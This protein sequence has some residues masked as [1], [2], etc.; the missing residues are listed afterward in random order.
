MTIQS[1]YKDYQLIFIKLPIF[2]SP[3]IKNSVLVGDYIYFKKV[4]FTMMHFTY[5]GRSFF[6]LIQ[7]DL[8]KLFL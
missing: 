2:K 7:I 8:G 5:F 4:K 3:G 1:I 6:L